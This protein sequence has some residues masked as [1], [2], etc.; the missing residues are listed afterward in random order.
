MRFFLLAAPLFF[1]LQ[2]IGQGIYTPSP[3]ADHN[4]A[5]NTSLMEALKEQRERIK[6]LPNREKRLADSYVKARSE[7]LY[8]LMKQ[9][10]FIFDSPLNLYLEKLFARILAAN[11]EIDPNTTLL[12]SRSGSINAFTTGDGFFVLNLGLLTEMKTESELA[13]VMGHEL[14]HQTLDHVNNAMRSRAQTEADPQRTKEI[15]RILRDEYRVSTKLNDF[16]LPGM[17]SSREFKRMQELEADSLGFL[18]ATRSGFAPEGSV[19]ALTILDSVD[20]SLY[21]RH[22]PWQHLYEANECH[23]NPVWKETSK[24][25]SLGSFNTVDK[26]LV[27]KLKTHPD[28]DLRIERLNAAHFIQRSAN[29]DVNYEDYRTIARM[30]LIESYRLKGDLGAALYHSIQ[31]QLDYPENEFAIE[32]AANALGLISLL[33][34]R[35]DLSGYVARYSTQLPE[36]YGNFLQ[37]LWEITATE[38]S[39]LA[40]RLN[41]EVTHP[42][43]PQRHL[44]IKAIAAYGNGNL[45]EAKRVAKAYS[46]EFPEGDQINEM[47]YFLKLNSK[48]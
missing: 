9:G 16:I 5:L 32:S 13:F 46:E 26:E 29:T 20:I 43:S 45:E 10:N 48:Q 40:Y 11:P 1:A 42:Y 15:R 31:L 25:S 34:K 44:A 2:A 3:M 14:A 17:V 41:S 19:R 36:D 39:C 21:G 47:E 33:K 37:V 4:E 28:C 22:I 7:M 8:D 18:Y 23:A 35:R 27:E 30:E 12:L 24:G 6:D 38:S